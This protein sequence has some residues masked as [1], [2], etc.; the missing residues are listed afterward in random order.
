MLLRDEVGAE[1]MRVP[2]AIA[3]EIRSFTTRDLSGLNQ[4]LR[5]NGLQAA[6]PTFLRSREEA[7]EAQSLARSAG[8]DAPN[9]A[10]FVTLHF[11]PDID[12]VRVAQELS[13][14]PEV[15][16]AM[17]VP[18]A[19]PPDAQP[20]GT[21]VEREEALEREIVARAREVVARMTIPLAEAAPAATPLNEPL[22]G[23]A[24]QVVLNPSTGLENQWYIYRCR[25]DK[26]WPLASGAG[27]VIAD[28]DWG[29]RTTHEDLSTRLNLA[30]A[31]NSYDGGTN[32]S[33]GS[34]ISHGTAVFGLAGGA[35][36]D[37]GM[38]GIAFSAELWP[39]QANSG[40]GAPLGGNAWA[41]A[42]DWVRTADSAGKRKVIILEVT[43]R[44]LRQLRDGFICE[45]R[46][47][48]GDCQRRGSV[49][50]GGKRG[51]RC[52]HRR[53]QQPDSRYRV[54]PRRRD[55][56]S[57]DRESSRVV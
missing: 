39:L 3:P 30:R 18:T 47:P 16:R 20:T 17:P 36:N 14:L 46:H 51:L 23:T 26:A 42:I 6:E 38:A 29:Y 25:V 55:R 45:R 24:D 48:D 19:L 35:D 41:R 28:I 31:Y 15:A 56:V 34:S 10:S 21:L 32:V 5:R 53:F 8:I 9:L 27:V 13:Q 7:A 52:G 40:P 57:P 54:H 33:H 12:V 4:V 49:R 2:N 11:A 37:K 1:V 43:D 50:R 44:H 22:V